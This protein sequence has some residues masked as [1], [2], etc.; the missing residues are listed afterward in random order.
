MPILTGPMKTARF[1]ELYES[2]FV[3]NRSTIDVGCKPLYTLNSLFVDNTLKGRNQNA[4]LINVIKNV[5]STPRDSRIRPIEKGC[6]LLLWN[7]PL[8]DSACRNKLYFIWKVYHHNEF[9]PRKS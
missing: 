3:I 5:Y 8:G 7:V 9:T 1:V 2:I 4:I 6:L